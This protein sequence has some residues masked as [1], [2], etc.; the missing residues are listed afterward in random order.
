MDSKCV[1]KNENVDS[2]CFSGLTVC[3][4]AEENNIWVHVKP[5]ATS[6]L[7]GS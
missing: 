6:P 7:R 4:D 5:L 3:L 2:L 1:A